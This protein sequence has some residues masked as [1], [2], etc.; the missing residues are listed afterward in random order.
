MPSALPRSMC[1]RTNHHLCHCRAGTVPYSVP[2][3]RF[4]AHNVSNHITLHSVISAGRSRSSTV[5]ALQFDCHY[6]ERKASPPLISLFS[7]VFI[8]LLTDP[9]LAGSIL[10]PFLVNDN[11][12]SRSAGRADDSFVQSFSHRNPTS[13]PIIVHRF[14]VSRF[15]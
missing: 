9:F 15:S 4:S 6:P 14:P 7:Y 8:K 10:R 13:S 5:P 11:G 1:K 3:R 12:R 2:S